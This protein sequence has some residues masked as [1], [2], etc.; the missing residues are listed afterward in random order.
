MVRR[1]N[2]AVLYVH[3]AAACAAFYEKTLGFKVSQTMGEHAV[4]MQAPLSDNDHDLALFSIGSQAG[5]SEAGRR[6]VG[7]YHLAWEVDTLAD[8][9][10]VRD[11][12]VEAGALAGASDHGASRSLYAKDPSGLE[13]EV[14]WEVPTDLFDPDL[15]RLGVAPLDL[16][17]DIARFG[18][19]ATRNR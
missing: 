5:S 12:L 15:D 3:D 6:T 18:L 19:E 8:L 10:A 16:D 2:H 13:F 4:F 7:L 1:L 17:A 11:R 9:V 14:M